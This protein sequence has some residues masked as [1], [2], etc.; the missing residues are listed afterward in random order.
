MPKNF[1]RETKAE[2]REIGAKFIFEKY[3][4]RNSLGSKQGNML[5][6]CKQISELLGITEGGRAIP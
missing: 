5:G 1:S 3:D 4:L 6:F 2:G